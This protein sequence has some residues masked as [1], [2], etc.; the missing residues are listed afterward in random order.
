[1]VIISI[2]TLKEFSKN[3]VL[4]EENSLPRAEIDALV[5]KRIRA[6]TRLAY[7]HNQFLHGLFDVAGIN[8]HSDITGKTDLLKAFRKGV[9]TTGADVPKLLADYAPQQSLVEVWS[10]GSSGIPKKVVMSK[11]GLDRYLRGSARGIM[12]QDVRDGDRLLSFAAPPPYASSVAFSLMAMMEHPRVTR[13]NFRSP[14]VPVGMSKMEREKV[15]KSY[16]DLIYDFGP[17]HV[18]GGTFIMKEFAQLMTEHGFDKN[19]LSLRSVRFGG[20]PVSDQDRDTIKN[21]WNAEPFDLYAST[22]AGIIAYECTAHSGMHVNEQ[23]LFITSVDL[24]SGEETGP[25]KVGKDLCTDLYQDGEAPAMFFINYSHK[26]NIALKADACP[27]GYAY[28]LIGHPT[29]DVRKK[30]L[31]GFGFDAR[32]RKQ[33]GALGKIRRALP[34]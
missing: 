28:K 30:P 27:C 23:D 7:D 9:K 1:M 16:I 12:L 17:H 3:K 13:L 26:D 10:S 6:V 19:R 33:T 4:N 22:E 34:V 18:G 24:E 8:P 31:V 20:D 32:G 25:G 14:S 2:I 21:L 29:R 11:S 5:D 15:I